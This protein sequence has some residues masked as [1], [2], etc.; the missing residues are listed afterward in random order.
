MASY[1]KYET[2]KGEFWRFQVSYTDPLT[3][4][5]KQKG[6]GGFETKREAKRFAQKLEDEISRGFLRNDKL[7]FGDVF[8]MWFENYQLT[9]KESTWTTTKRNFENHILPVLG[10]R[11]IN[12]ITPTIC[13]KIVNDWFNRPLKNY[14]RFFNNVKNVFEYA[15]QLKIIVDDPTKAV[16]RPS[17]KHQKVK[18]KDEKSM[19]YTREEL[20]QFLECMYDSD[21]YQGYAFF[22]LLAFTG[23]RKGEALALTWN[24]VDFVSRQITINKT[25]SNGYDRL[26]V[27]STK[28]AA[29]DRV[30]FIDQKTMSIL[31]T[32][33][34]KQRVELFHLGFNSMNEN[35]LVF[36]SYKNTMHNPNKPRVWAV[37]VTKNYD[38]KHIPVHGFRH[39]YAT[40]A[41]QGGMPPKELQKQLGHSD[42]KTTLDIYTSVTDQQLE[43]TPEKYTAFVNF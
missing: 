10:N 33:Q 34:K 20:K 39:T 29:S 12:E 19:Y 8:K 36:A 2:H 6:K 14:K 21:N 7:T 16:I 26:V 18:K 9:T 42:I 41:I 5:R 31:K 28:T 32:W 43:Q 27:Q 24:D 13:Q 23:M 30:I 35:Q 38:L 22:R 4:K 11:K 40:L 37:R 17:A 1:T 15:V 25:Q 3:G